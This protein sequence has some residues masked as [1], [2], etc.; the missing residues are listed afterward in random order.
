MNRKR[1]TVGAAEG[2]GLRLHRP[3]IRARRPTGSEGVGSRRNQKRQDGT[4]HCRVDLLAL[5]G[6]RSRRDGAEHANAREHAA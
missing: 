4:G 6:F 2:V 5:A 1:Q 3:S